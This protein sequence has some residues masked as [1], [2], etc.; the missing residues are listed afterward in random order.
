MPIETN[1]NLNRKTKTSCWSKNKRVKN[2][3]RFE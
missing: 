3:S 2:T 1:M